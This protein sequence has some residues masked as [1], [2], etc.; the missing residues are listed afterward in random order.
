[1]TVLA[2]IERLTDRITRLEKA[3]KAPPRKSWK[4][5]EIAAMTGLGYDTVLE[6]IHDGTLR[7]KKVG[8]LYVVADEEIDRFLGTKEAA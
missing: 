8:Q 5:R 4:P 7:A 2:A 6:L 1:M 3:V